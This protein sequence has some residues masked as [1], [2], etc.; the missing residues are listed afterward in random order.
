MPDRVAECGEVQRVRRGSVRVGRQPG[1]FTIDDEPALGQADRRTGAT[2]GA[3]R[4]IQVVDS[5]VDRLADAGAVQTQAGKV[6]TELADAREEPLQHVAL[7]LP[8]RVANDL[9]LLAGE[10][11]RAL[12]ADVLVV[13]DAQNVGA[14]EGVSGLIARRPARRPAD[15]CVIGRRG[16]D[17]E[18]SCGAD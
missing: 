17:T 1:L 10:P 3:D 14:A 2:G 13:G 15:G 18:T 5:C 8:R 9:A 12:H 7:N 6:L 16:S 4:R 11:L